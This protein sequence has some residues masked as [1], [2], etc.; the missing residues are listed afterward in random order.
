M[1][2][3]D[4]EGRT[5]K[6][7]HTIPGRDVGWSILDVAFSPDTHSIAYTSWSSNSQYITMHYYH[8]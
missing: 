4:C 5:F 8:H 1:R 6:V 7:I 2:V 3:Y